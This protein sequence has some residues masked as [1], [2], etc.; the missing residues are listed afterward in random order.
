MRRTWIK[1]WV[2]AWLDGTTRFEMSGAQRA[3]WIDLLALA[4]RSRHPGFIYAGQSGDRVIGYPISFFQGLDAGGELDVPATLQLFEACGKVKVEVTQEAPVR[5]LKI[6]ILNWDKYQSEYQRQKGYRGSYKQSYKQSAK[7]VTTENTKRL[8]VEGEGEGEG[9]GETEKPSGVCVQPHQQEHLKAFES[10]WKSY[11]RKEAKRD[12]LRAW[13]KIQPADVAAILKGLQTA[14]RSEQWQRGVIPHAAT[15]LNGRR[16]E[17]EG[18]SSTPL[19]A[20]QP[21]HRSESEIPVLR[22]DV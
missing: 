3:F 8:L 17:D 15:W 10:F 2:D 21:K 22:E 6:E 20:A 19:L 5:L 14:I 9:E 4:G 11:P 13:K 18:S 16:W 12:A 7:K 1:V